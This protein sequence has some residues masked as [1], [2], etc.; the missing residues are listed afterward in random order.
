MY[1]IP[2]NLNKYED[3]FIP[4]VR[5][6]F[7]QFV[8]F[9]LLIGI[10]AVAYQSIP[11]S[12]MLKLSA[13]LPLG[14][15]G[16]V[17]IHVR[18]DEKLISRLNLR[19]SLRNVGYY[20]SKMEKLIPIHS[21]H[22]NAIYLKNGIMLA[23]LEVKPIDFSML[24]DDEKESVLHNYRGFLK[25]LDFPLQVC[26][27]SAEVNLSTW[28]LNLR[29]LAGENSSRTHSDARINALSVWIEQ[30]IKSSG[31]RNRLF[32]IIVPFRDFSEQKSLANSIRELLFYLAG[33]ELVLSGKRKVEF[34]KSLRALSGRVEDI[35]EMIAKT[36]VK[37]RRLNSN[38]LLSLY[39]N[40]FTDLFEIDVSYLSPVMWSKNT[41]EEK[42]Q[43]F[44]R[45]KVFDFLNDGLDGSLLNGEELELAS[46]IS[47][48]EEIC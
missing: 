38:E 30:E 15:I 47:S 9:L 32:Y 45:A 21:I 39:A 7:R 27:R 28:L 44:A 12:P 18:A 1:E 11:L 8:Y 4:F 16:L 6:N 3:E 2:K 19:A 36:G 43:K 20:D 5:W 23:I 14:A 41:S 37:A 29:K 33:K 48:G 40:Y 17:L 34:A 46:K 24:G 22:E 25:A 42:F 10:S 13:L 26:C 35:G 31:T